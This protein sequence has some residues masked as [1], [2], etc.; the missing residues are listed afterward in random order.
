MTDIKP[1]TDE[2]TKVAEFPTI[3]IEQ[4]IAE[5]GSARD[6]LNVALARLR[7][8]EAR[9]VSMDAEHKNIRAEVGASQR[10]ADVCPGPDVCQERIATLNDRIQATKEKE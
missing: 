8:L 2:Y 9:I 4:W 5:H 1:A 10:L 7:V 3:E 6:A